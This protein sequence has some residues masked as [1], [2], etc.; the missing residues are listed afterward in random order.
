VRAEQRYKDG[1]AVIQ[2]LNNSGYQ[3]CMEGLST[4]ANPITDPSKCPQVQQVAQAVDA[5][6]INVFD[7]WAGHVT[8]GSLEPVSAAGAGRKSN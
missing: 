7:G 5:A 4:V 8:V 2:R 6:A 1:M 3:Y